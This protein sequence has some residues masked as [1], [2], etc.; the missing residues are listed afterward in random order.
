MNRRLT[1]RLTILAF[2]TPSVFGVFLFFVL[3]FGVVIWYSLIDSPMNRNFVFLDNYQA[4]L[5]NG[6]FLLAARN[7][8]VFS[9]IAVPLSVILSLL[10]ALLLESG[11]PGKSVFR[12]IFLSPVVVPIASVVLIWQVIFHYNG[13]LNS[14]LV[15]VGLIRIDWLRSGCNYLVAVV[16]FLWKNLGYNM[17]L[18]AAAL[19][20]VPK[21]LL[22]AASIDGAGPF[23]RFFRIK[24]R[25]LS[26]T[27]LFV[28]IL[29]LI[30]SFKVFREVW[31]L[32]GDYPL[33]GMYM[34]QHFIN[35]TFGRLEY[36]KLSSAAVV[37]GL[38]MMAVIGI[39][40]L[41]EGRFGKDVEN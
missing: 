1:N 5:R 13:A 9:A 29:S 22:E 17:V 31:L 36:D 41:A 23:Y 10:L 19:G 14:I 2:L 27:V 12:V 33:E 40:F 16:L 3:P 6:S 28:T 21:E 34:L 11:I 32:A 4:I 37:M 26:P 30:N 35:N 18:F 7:T 39:L 15:R 20:N 38:V 8:A 25:F 24:L